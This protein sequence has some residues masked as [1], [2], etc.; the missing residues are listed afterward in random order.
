MPGQNFEMWTR[1]RGTSAD[2]GCKGQ[3]ADFSLDFAI[4]RWM[5][6]GKFPKSHKVAGYIAA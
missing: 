5:H 3:E 4:Y 1:L 6:E 2:T